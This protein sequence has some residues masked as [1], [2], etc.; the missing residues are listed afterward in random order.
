MLDVDQGF[1]LEKWLILLL[2]MFLISQNN[3]KWKKNNKIG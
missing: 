2:K 3:N 1:Y